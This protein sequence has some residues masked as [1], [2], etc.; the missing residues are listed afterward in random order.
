MRTPVFDCGA[1]VGSRLD[2]PI[3]MRKL[4][5]CLAVPLLAFTPTVGCAQPDN[6]FFARAGNQAVAAGSAAGVAIAVVRNGAIVYEGGFGSADLA[7]HVATTASTRFAIGSLTKQLTAAVIDVLAARGKLSLDDPLGKYVPSLPNANAITLRMLL[8][9][10]SGLHNYPNLQEHHWPTSGSVATAAIIAM[11]ASDKPDFT[12]GTR[13]EYSNA[14]YA[15]LTAVAERV[16]GL[17]FG[18]L[19]QQTIFGPLGMRESGY[20]YAAQSSGAPAVGYRNGAP[21]QPPLTLDLFSGAGGAV[22]S[23]HDFALWD[24]ALLGGTLLPKSYLDDVW[25]AGVATGEGDARYAMGWVL[26]N[27]GGHREM[28]HNGLAP[29]VGGYCYNAVFPDDGLAVAIFTNGFGAEGV[30]ERTTRAIAAAYGIGTPAPAATPPAAAA[31]DNPAIDALARAFWNGLATGTIDR[32][33]LTADFSTALTP[34]LLNQVRQGIELLGTL[35]SFTFAGATPNGGLTTYRYSLLFDGGIEH[36]WDVTMTAD[37][38]IAGS[39]LV[40]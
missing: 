38:K 12:P 3:V 10:R 28:W 39:R 29:G 33:K 4:A 13:W 15:A 30:P 19:L 26:A 37:M 17:A 5:L 24:A 20:G 35:R 31:G 32:S 27:T 23:V 22:S 1:D 11:L 8:D 14:N 2:L 18:A 16:S 7:T 25:N 40:R 36:E 34:A 9:Q 21:E 6:D